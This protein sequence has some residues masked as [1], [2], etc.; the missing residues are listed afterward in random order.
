MHGDE[1]AP[2]RPGE[3][4]VTGR[5]GP[6]HP[7]ARL[8]VLV[9]RQVTE[10]AERNGLTPM[11]ARMLSI[12]T[13]EPRRMADLALG[14]GIEKAALTGLVDRAESRGLVVRGPVPGDRRAVQLTVTDAGAAAAAAFHR[15][16]DETLDALVDTLP[17]GRRAA[18]RT[19]VNLLA[20][21]TTDGSPTGP[22]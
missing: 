22:C 2:S 5:G 1:T 14:L 7:L 17:T 15:Q 9:H 8:S 12:L 18:F 21:T 3:M 16:L 6:L 11:Q 19:A 20:D 4:C 10:V 13:A